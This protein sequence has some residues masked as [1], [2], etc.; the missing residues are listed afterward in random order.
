MNSEPRHEGDYTDRQVEAA[1]RVLVDVGQV[2]APFREAIVVVGGWVPDLLFP[3]ADPEHVGSID[4]DLALDVGKLGD[5]RYA[6]LLKLLLDTNRYEKG[7]KDFQLVT[8][9]DLG[10]GE[11]P[12]KVDVEFLAPA[13][14]KL[15]KNHPKLIEGFRVLQFPATAAAFGQPKNIDLEGAMISGAPNTVHLRVASLPDFII[16]KAHA[17]GGRDK[18]K[19]VYDLCYCLDEFPDAIAVVAGDWRSRRAD[20]LVG[21]AIEILKEKF[22]AVQH[23]GPQQL[24]IFYDSTDD[25]EREMRARRAFELVQKLLN[26]I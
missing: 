25:D 24:A 9:V 5:G 16:M 14:V 3:G 10:D 19:D 6:E 1:H 11:V 13:D 17:V 7:D 20:P 12:V 26:L 21:S 2:L 22:K 15:K 23:Y 18:P 8:T 4:V